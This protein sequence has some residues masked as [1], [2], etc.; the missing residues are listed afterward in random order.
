MPEEK[1]MPAAQ[2]APAEPK[3]AGKPPE[4]KVLYYILS[5]LISLFGI[6]FGIIYM[7]KEGEENKKFGKM[8]LILGL[9]P[10]IIACVCWL[11]MFVFGIGSGFLSE[12]TSTNYNY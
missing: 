1:P 4:P 6:I 10:L 9:L 3:G 8:C 5:F 2:P 11:L 7:T 12:G